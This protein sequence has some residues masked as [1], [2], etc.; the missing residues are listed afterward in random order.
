MDDSS[1]V[2]DQSYMNLK[3]DNSPDKKKQSK[4]ILPK[5]KTEEAE[6]NA[7]NSSP[8]KLKRMKRKIL[9]GY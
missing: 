6:E 5:L 1:K 4:I 8:G 3:E 9:P 2:L 7:T